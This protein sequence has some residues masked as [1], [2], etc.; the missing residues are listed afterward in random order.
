MTIDDRTYAGIAWTLHGH[1]VRGDQI[2][3]APALLTMRGRISQPHGHASG[4]I[5]PIRDALVDCLGRLICHG[6]AS[7]LPGRDPTL[8]VGDVRVP[9]LLE[10]VSGKG[11]ASA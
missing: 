6:V 9:E 4:I 2:A 10:G 7:V 1:R 5:P 8:E 3:W 11:R